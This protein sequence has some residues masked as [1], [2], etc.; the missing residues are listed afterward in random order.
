MTQ[1]MSSTEAEADNEPNVRG[2]GEQQKSSL[3][4]RG[5]DGMEFEAKP[6]RDTGRGA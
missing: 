4:F 2:T 5:T 3:K 6:E 1:N